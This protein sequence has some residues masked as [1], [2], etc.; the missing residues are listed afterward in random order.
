MCFPIFEV[1]QWGGYTTVLALAFM[2]LVLLYSPLAVE[3]IRVSCWLLFLRRLRLFCRISL[4]AFLAVFILPPILI[5]MLIKSR[6]AYLKVCI[7]VNFRRGHSVFP[8]LFPSHD[9][10]PRHSY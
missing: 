7:R 5:F 3:K 1:N 2:L 6:G 4:A 8:L 10:L 9:R